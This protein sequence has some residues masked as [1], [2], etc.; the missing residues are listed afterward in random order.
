M[1]TVFAALGA[2][3]LTLAT[4]QAGAQAVQVQVP[5]NVEPVRSQL[6][7]AEVLADLHLYRAAGVYEYARTVHVFDVYTYAYK[8]RN[9][10]YLHLRQ[11]PQ[12][13]QLV[14]ELERNP[15]AR[16]VANPVAASH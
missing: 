4:G 1:R 3:A 10:T 9:A 5:S 16:V 12:Y 6:T 11:S 13:A 7:K 14:S 15:R 8:K 2:F